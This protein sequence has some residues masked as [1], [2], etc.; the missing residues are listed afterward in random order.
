MMRPRDR[1]NAKYLLR[2]FVFV[3]TFMRVFGVVWVVCSVD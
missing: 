3:R 2:R 1:L